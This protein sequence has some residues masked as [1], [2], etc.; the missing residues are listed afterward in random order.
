QYIK[1]ADEPIAAFAAPVAAVSFL[2]SARSSGSVLFGTGDG[3]NMTIDNVR[4]LS[5][6]YNIDIVT[7]NY[8]GTNKPALTAPETVVP[9]GDGGG[10]GSIAGTAAAIPAALSAII[11]AV[12]LKKKRSPSL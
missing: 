7:E 5:L 6:E 8:D 1:A 2:T 4:I 3:G 9:P 11:A 10:C 12:L